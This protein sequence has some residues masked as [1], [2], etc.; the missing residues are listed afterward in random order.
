M[1]DYNKYEMD[2]PITDMMWCGSSNEV[3][4]VLT[5]AGTVYRSRDRGQAWK[6]LQGIM[7]TAGN[8]VK[9]N[10]QEVSYKKICN[11]TFALSLLPVILFFVLL[12]L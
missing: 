10:D 8:E 11:L 12:L 9:D 3:I 7:A 1:I 5:N 4:L 2:A 6:K